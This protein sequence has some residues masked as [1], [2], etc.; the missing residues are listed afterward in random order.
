MTGQHGVSLD[1]RVHS[2]YPAGIRSLAQPVALVSEIDKSPRRQVLDAVFIPTRNRTE[3]VAGL[4]DELS[5]LDSPIFIIPSSDRDIELLS[6]LQRDRVQRLPMPES[7][8]RHFLRALRTSQLRFAPADWGS[9]DL[10]LK[11]NAVLLFL[12]LD[13]DIRSIT[14]TTVLRGAAS[15]G[16]YPLS[17]CFIEGFPD[18]SVLGHLL[19]AVGVCEPTFLSGSFIFVDPQ[20]TRAFFPAIYNE[21]WLFMLPDLLIKEVCSVGTVTQLPYDPFAVSTRAVFEE[22][23]DVV[24]DALF[25]LVLDGGYDSRH[26]QAFWTEAIAERKGLLTSLVGNASLNRSQLESAQAALQVCLSIEPTDCV[27]FVE[28]WERDLETWH[29]FV[30]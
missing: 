14:P 10:S 21:D 28:A 13:D 5:W 30:D 11:R 19:R 12:F 23:G 29:A 9:W 20:R 27:E 6:P 3:N 24:V 26:S 18:T 15:L 8:F 2:T 7:D 1:S 16:S 25:G 4:L 22:F 17:G